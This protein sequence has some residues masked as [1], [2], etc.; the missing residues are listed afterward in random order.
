MNSED[1]GTISCY[2]LNSK[3]FSVFSKEWYFENIDQKSNTKLF[4]YKTLLF[5][6]LIMSLENN[7]NSKTLT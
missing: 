3:L 4:R 6:A 1:I 2:K 5:S 7:F